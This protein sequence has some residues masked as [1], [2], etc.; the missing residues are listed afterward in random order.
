MFIQHLRIICMIAFGPFAI[1]FRS[2]F[3]AHWCCGLVV[4][5]NPVDRCVSVDASSP[6]PSPPPPHNNKVLDLIWTAISCAR[7]LARIARTLARNSIRTISR[8]RTLKRTHADRRRQRQRRVSAHVTYRIGSDR[9]GCVAVYAKW[10]LPDFASVGPPVK[11]QRCCKMILVFWWV[12]EE[13]GSW[14]C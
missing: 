9:P 7:T 8:G 10:L 4:R 5:A 1:Y 2:P 14:L 3:D 6:P 11:M 13:I 12:A